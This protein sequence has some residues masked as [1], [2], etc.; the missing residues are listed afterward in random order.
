MD[1]NMQLV[2]FLVA[3]SHADDVPEVAC[4]ISGCKEASVTDSLCFQ[5][6]AYFLQQNRNI[7]SILHNIL[8]FR[9]CLLVLRGL[10]DILQ[11]PNV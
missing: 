8:I 11:F 5:V 6:V 9:E 2:Q 3:S 7:A 4:L 1:F 10:A